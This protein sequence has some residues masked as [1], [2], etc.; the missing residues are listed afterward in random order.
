[1]SKMKVN[2]YLD[3]V[4]LLVYLI[5]MEPLFTGIT[6]HEWI[7]LG[8]GLAFIVHILLHWKWVVECTKRLFTKLPKRTKLNY[9][10]NLLML[11]GSIFIILSSFAIART[12]NFSWLGLGGYTYTW[13][14]IHVASSFLVLILVGIHLGL[15][16]KWTICAFKKIFQ[17]N[18]KLPAILKFPLVLLTVGLGIYSIVYIDLFA[19]LTK[20]FS[21]FDP[22]ISSATPS[23]GKGHKG[24]GRGGIH[25]LT[26]T[27]DASSI[28]GYLGITALLIVIVYYFDKAINKITRANRKT[29]H[30]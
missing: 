29:S 28:L 12:I 27:S 5:I 24:G 30:C 13:F 2:L 20:T 11:V 3:F 8:L 17:I 14:Q 4:L 16:W 9:L 1:M 26:A 23:T 18:Y 21:F 15:H 6:L 22:D 25:S 7:G 10:L 19:T